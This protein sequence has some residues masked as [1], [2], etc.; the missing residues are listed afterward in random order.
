LIISD[1]EYKA[2][3]SIINK[4]SNLIVHSPKKCIVNGHTI[5]N[6]Y[7]DK[8]I[9]NVLGAGDCFSS[10]VIT[11]CVYGKKINKEVIDFSNFKTYKYLTRDF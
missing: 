7:Y 3:K 10:H 8:K 1:V 11:Q 6:R 9:K 5:K 2:A 4:K